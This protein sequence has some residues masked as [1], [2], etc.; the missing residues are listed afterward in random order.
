MTKH[1]AAIVMAYTG[2]TML[3][4]DDFIIFAEYCNKLLGFTLNVEDYAYLS[5]IIKD[6]SKSDFIQIC[7][8]LTD[9]KGV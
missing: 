5:D 2:I 3:T 1:E 7:Q 4:H 9:D 8:N 6:K